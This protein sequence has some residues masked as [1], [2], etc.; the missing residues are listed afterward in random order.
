[1][2][3]QRFAPPPELADFVET[4]WF[5]QA[6]A[7]AAGRE[8]TFPTGQM[9]IIVSLH[10]D[11]ISLPHREQPQKHHTFPG[12]IVLGAA[13][14]YGVI[15]R[16]VRSEIAGVQFRPGG[17]FP[18][19]GYPAGDFQDGNF[20]L[21]DVWGEAARELRERLLTTPDI[22]SRYRG[23]VEA[24]LAQA[25]GPLQRH[26]GVAYAL[27]EL[28][29]VPARASVHRMT[30]E[31]GLS[32][33]RF[34]Q[35]FRDQVGLPPKLFGRVRR[36]QSVVNRV[37]G[38]AE[39]DWVDEALLSGYYDQSHFAHDFRAFTGLTPAAYLASPG[40]FVNHVPLED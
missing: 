33:K 22:T 15:E 20:A 30:S 3:Y 32:P 17:G 19:F 1:M 16:G 24:L 27:R 14:R 26:P 2:G 8:R 36:F 25:R 10:D 5:Y 4:I 13:S 21:E 28:R 39:V 11:T 9:G 37:F 40:E 31:V 23:V 12:A 34:I 35:L 29:R 7:S 18:F 6:D 38:R